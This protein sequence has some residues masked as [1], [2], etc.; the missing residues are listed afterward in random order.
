LRTA[1]ARSDLP[2]TSCFERGR[3]RSHGLPALLCLLVAGCAD[4]AVEDHAPLP[5]DEGKADSVHGLDE[6]SPEARAILRLANTASFEVLDKDVRLDRRA[7]RGIVDLRPEDGYQSLIELD[8]VPFVGPAAFRKMLAYVV[9]RGLVGRGLR[10]GT[11]NI[12]W[13]GLGGSF[14]GSFGSETRNATIRD[15]LEQHLFDRDVLVF[16]EIVDV[17]LFAEEVMFDWT[18]LTYD[19]F[20]GKHQHVVL[21][22]RDDFELLPADDSGGFGLAELQLGNHNLRPGL[23]G[24][25]V[26][27]GGELVAHIVGVHLKARA[28][29]TEARLAQ[30]EVLAEYV[31]GR[32]AH[33]SR[34][35][36]LI[37]DF[38][39][40]V[41]E[42]TGHPADD[43]VLLAD[44]LEADGILAWV[45]PPEEHTF[46]NKT[47]AAHRLDHA[48][49]SAEITVLDA[50]VPGPC[51]LD[52][53]EDQAAITAYFD[54][55]SDHCPLVL[56][57]ELP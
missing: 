7:A 19:G 53:V 34:P 2:P 20:S 10:V 55:V 24:D 51:N 15:F 16:Q 8:T 47:G 17:A 31:R 32:A 23:H 14:F 42:D 35:F 56:D 38:N 22:H 30:A 28:D 49:L 26:D 3:G 13:Y 39:T 6:D 44:T 4:S 45:Q 33:S 48:W 29:S 1:M 21:C 54:A 11:F 37:G 5:G 50:V 57:L 27:A 18:C 40:H 43:E 12:R 41:A 9:E 52:P 25:L 46:R 36:L